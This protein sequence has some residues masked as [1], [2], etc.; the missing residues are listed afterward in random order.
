LSARVAQILTSN[1]LKA[2][3][4]RSTILA[5]V[6]FGGQNAIRLLSSLVLTRLLFP[7]AFGL[8]A[9]VQ[10]VLTG[11]QLFSDIG[12]REAVIQDK[13]GGD[14]DFLNTAWVINIG[15]GFLLWFV[16]LLLAAPIAEFYDAPQLAE[17]LPIAG[18][19]AVFQGFGSTRILVADRELAIGRLTL[20]AIGTQI[21]GVLVMIALAWYTESVWSLVIG[22]LATTLSAAILSHLVLPGE[23]VRLAFDLSIAQRIIGFGKYIFLATI[24]GFIVA[25]ADR[26]VLGKFVPL[27]DLAIYN[28]G[29]MLAT[30]PLLLAQALSIRIIFPLYSRT[31]PSESA[32]ARHNIN[33]A[34]RLLTGGLLT[35]SAVL[36][37]FGIGLI[38]ILYDPRYEA[39]GPIVVLISLSMIPTI[40]TYSYHRLATAAGHSGRF[41]TVTVSIALLQLGA[42][43]VGI[44]FFG[45][46]GAAVAPAVATLVFYPALI[47]LIR[48]YEGWDPLHDAAYFAVGLV[49]TGVALWLSGSAMAPLFA[50]L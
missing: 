16:T 26:A 35:G 9:L 40:V 49:I 15:R 18:L 3:A 17:L 2:K 27:E 6:N 28:I 34:R 13:R 43:M 11:L 45:L 20:L 36:A 22:W 12:L 48:K 24:A 47:V 44:Q 46:G 38:E 10:V 25:Q 23:R 1:S 14:P 33:R 4:T 32:K 42:L 41:A 5:I 21:F 19:T 31:P 37:L 8:M 30:V 39:A 7:E 29:L 50:P